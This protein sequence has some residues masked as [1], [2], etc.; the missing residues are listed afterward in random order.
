[1]VCF[2]FIY[3]FVVGLGHRIECVNAPLAA[4]NLFHEAVAASDLAAL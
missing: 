2:V 4:L 3:L 1:M